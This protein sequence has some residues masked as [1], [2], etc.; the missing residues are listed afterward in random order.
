MAGVFWGNTLKN[1][2]KMQK[3]AEM[4]EYICINAKKVVPLH[5]FF[6]K[7]ERAKGRKAKGRK[8]ER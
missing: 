6:I 7:G 8:D 4:R 3:M 5:A 2:H 1:C